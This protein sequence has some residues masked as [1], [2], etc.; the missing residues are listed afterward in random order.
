MIRNKT[1]MS[2]PATFIHVILKGLAMSIKE[3]KEVKGIQIGQEEIKLS[4]FGDD[5]IYTCVCY[6]YH[7]Q[8]CK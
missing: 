1:R 5:M 2:T 7:N 3:G 4:V 6:T 8:I